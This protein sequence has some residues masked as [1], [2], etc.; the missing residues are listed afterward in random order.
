MKS[1][2]VSVNVALAEAERIACQPTVGK[3][4]AH[5][6]FAGAEEIAEIAIRVV[7]ICKIES[8]IR[9]SRFKLP[10]PRLRNKKFTTLTIR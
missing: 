10:L 7:D 9:P 6:A 8:E 2:V 1:L 4:V 3:S 5:A